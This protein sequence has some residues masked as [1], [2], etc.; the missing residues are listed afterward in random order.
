MNVSPRPHRRHSGYHVGAAFTLGLALVSGG[1]VRAGTH[2][3]VIP[4]EGR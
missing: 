2:D 3:A 1:A 4:Q